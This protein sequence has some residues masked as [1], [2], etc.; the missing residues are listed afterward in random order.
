MQATGQDGDQAHGVHPARADEEA[1]RTVPECVEEFLYSRQARKQSPHTLAAYRR[2]LEG[3]AAILAAQTGTAPDRLEIAQV[4]ARP[5]R[6]AFAAYAGPRSAASVGRAW[7]VWNQFFTFLVADAVAP[8]NPMGAVERPRAPHRSPKPLRGP[9]TP[10]QLLGAAAAPPDPARRRDPWPERDLAVLAVLLCA[11]LRSSELLG[12]TLSSIDGRP[13]ERYLRVHG[14]GGKDRAIPV[15]PELDEVITL[16]LD[17]R[18]ARQA[19]RAPARND[20]LFAGRDGG[21]LGRGALQYLVGRA[22][23]EAAVGAQ[24]PQ[25]ALVHALRHTFATRLAEDGASAAEIMRLLGHASLTTSQN[26]IDATAREQ[27]GA[28]RANRTHQALRDLARHRADDGGAPAPRAD[29]RPAED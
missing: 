29:A 8:G 15:E 18:T 25:G 6:Q 11:G 9:D 21:P 24:V 7:S 20:P 19:G 17:S 3:V 14:K 16:Y 22:Y 5:L 13:G 4:G 12:L 28:I 27:R 10:E 23:R 1:L 26:Y 2:D